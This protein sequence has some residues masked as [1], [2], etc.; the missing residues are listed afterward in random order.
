MTISRGCRHGLSCATCACSPYVTANGALAQ[1]PHSPSREG[2]ERASVTE[3][4]KEREREREKTSPV[5]KSVGASVNVLSS[6]APP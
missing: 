3:R 4:E 6:S 2:T 1:E 5:D